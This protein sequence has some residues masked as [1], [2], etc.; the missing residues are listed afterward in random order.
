MPDSTLDF[1]GGYVV[2]WQDVVDPNWYGLGVEMSN[3]HLAKWTD[4]FCDALADLFGQDFYDWTKH[5]TRWPV[6]LRVTL[7]VERQ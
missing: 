1:R 3:G 4:L 5:N 6:K 7:A 2:L